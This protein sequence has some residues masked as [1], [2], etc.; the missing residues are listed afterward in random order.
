MFLLNKK[1]P[2]SL[3]ILPHLNTSNVSIKLYR[4]HMGRNEKKHLN[5][6]NVSIKHVPEWPFHIKIP[7]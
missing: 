5:T 4:Q 6:S 1:R 7:I 3:F 2:P